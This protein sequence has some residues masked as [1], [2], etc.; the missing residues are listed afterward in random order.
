MTRLVA[1]FN[2]AAT[3][4]GPVS[5][6]SPALRSTV[7][8]TLGSGFGL[9][10]WW[11]K[12]LIQIYNDAYRP[13]LGSKHPHQALGRPVGECWN[14]IIDIIRPLI[15]QP[16]H[17]GP[18]SVIDDLELE[19][20]RSDFD[21]EAHFTVAYSPVFDE[22]VEGGIGGVL[23]T[24]QETTEKVIGER[25]MRLLRDLAVVATKGQTVSEQCRLALDVM[26]H[27]ERDV[28]FSLIYLNAGDDTLELACAKGLE[29]PPPDVTL[30]GSSPLQSGE[31]DVIDTRHGPCIRTP[32]PASPAH[33]SSGVL[34][35]GIGTKLRF[36]ERYRDFYVLVASQIGSAIASARAHEE[37]RRRAEA[38]AE[39]DRAKTAFFSN[40]SHEFRTPLTL[41]LGPLSELAQKASEAQRPLVDSAY[42]NSL[43]LLKL[44]NTLLE[45]SRLQAGRAEVAY[46]KTDLSA[47]TEEICSVFRSA[48]E[49][50]GLKFGLDMALEDDVYVDRTLWEKVVLNLLSNALKFTLEGEI[51]VSLRRVGDC[52]ELRV[53]DTGV[54]IPASERAHVFERFRR[55]RGTKARSHEGSGIGLAL[56]KD[57]VALQSGSIDVESELGK[58]STFIVRLPLGVAHLDAAAIVQETPSSLRSHAV[59]EQYL[60]E[61]DATFLGAASR[62]SAGGAFDATR[63]RPRLLLADDNRD[64]RDYATRILSAEYDV[65]AV[66]NGVEALAAARAQHFDAIV[67]DVMM[68]EMDGLELLRAVRADPALATL[69]FIML[70]ARAGEEY[71]VEG[72]AAGADDY[73]AKPFSASELL[74]R[75]R[76]HLYG[77]E[78]RRHAWRLSE[79]RFRSFAEAVPVAVWSATA[80]GGFDWYNNRWYE[81]TGQTPGEA[82]GW[83]WQ[84]ACFP[85]DLPRIMEAWLHA[86]AHGTTLEVEFRLRRHDGAYRWFLARA[87]AHRDDSGQIVRWYGSFVDIETQK[88]ALV[89]PKRVAEALQSAFLPDTFPNTG[90]VRFDAVY[91]AAEKDALIGGD[92][93][94]AVRLPDGKM[95]ISIGDVAGHGIGASI[96]AASIRQAMIGFSLNETDPAEILRHA[97]RVA[98]FQYPETFATAVVGIIE[99]DCTVISYACAGHPA[100]MLAE[101]NGEPAR[102]LP[103]GGIPLGVSDTLETVVHRISLSPDSILVL[104]TD[105]LVEFGRDIEK[106]EKTLRASVGALLSDPTLVRPAVT[107]QKALLGDGRPVDDVAILLARFSTVD[108]QTLPVDPAS[109]VKEWRFHSSDAHTAGTSRRELTKFIQRHAADPESVY[110]AELILGEILANTVE[111]APGLVS[112]RIDWSGEKPVA[113]IRDHGP[114][115]VEF[116]G[117]L[118]A[119]TFDVGGRGL[120]LIKALADSVAVDRTSG[121]GTEL[122]VALPVKR[123][124]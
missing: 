48:I 24:V 81:Y 38:L 6:W 10:L 80:D 92:W 56:V 20:R 97:N 109:L 65:T 14:E 17:G 52:A 54:G 67:S 62:P 43:R 18:P 13:V 124:L 123:T 63:F 28:P 99:S 110:V 47:L 94:D 75:V 102:L 50:V 59:A 51:H 53:R 32:I 57:L 30:W 101:T 89:G 2:W 5:S 77:S 87:E 70:S 66:G 107:L 93:F 58:G 7:E 96:I 113:T 9:L 45:F 44:V 36:D 12:D 60:A 119:D 69:P 4:L 112:I 85:E 34:V 83:G 105:G 108:A 21:E 55:V 40:V 122:R 37:E 103:A 71:A 61:V 98:R 16:L 19:L 86:L 41:M 11:G 118:P 76:A 1:E 82:S 117:G 49:G 95:L 90:R 78:I 68:P 79:E 73:I 115:L 114:G 74:A 39:V 23:A 64:L 106:A 31:V 100:P 33:E 84:A 88:D 8:N 27:Y 15:E 22:S 25:R 104:Y 72:V 121:A 35:A 3:P 26:A 116:F 42:R 91:V 29:A 120:F 46:A 111:H